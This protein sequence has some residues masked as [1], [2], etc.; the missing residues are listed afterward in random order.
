MTLRL[1]VLSLLVFFCVL[2]TYAQTQLAARLDDLRRET[3]VRLALAENAEMRAYEVTVDVADGIVVLSG[4]VPTL[5]TRDNVVAFVSGL[6][7]VRVVRSTLRLEG[8]PDQSLPDPVEP[9]H[10]VEEADTTNRLENS[11]PQATEQAPTGPVYHSVRRGDT[12][13]GIARRYE[14]SVNAISELN[15]LRSTTVRIGQ[16]L[17][18]K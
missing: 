11:E 18:V 17:R 14:T 5:G 6:R 2:P 4:L 13:Y 16:R 1:A 9:A 15:D 12:L 3:S 7:G 8:R 10:R